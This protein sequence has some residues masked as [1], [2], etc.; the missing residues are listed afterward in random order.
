MALLYAA[1]RGSKVRKLAVLLLAGAALAGCG[2]PREGVSV[3]LI[4]ADS[5]RVDR[6]PLWNPGEAPPTPNLDR[7]AQRGAAYRNAWATSPWTAPAM[8]SVFTGLYPPSHGIVYRDDTTPETLPTLPRLLAAR[9]YRL[10][11][12]SFF[13]GISYFRNLGLGP[14]EEGIGH[15]RVAG[16]FRRWL[17]AVPAEQPFFAWVH[18][19]EPH[20]PYGA[21]G[22]RAT[23]AEV[24]GSSGLVAAQLDATVPWG[25][26]EFEDG[27]RGR[28]VELYDRDVRRMDEVLG[29]VLDA[30]ESEGRAGETLVI[31]VADHGEELLDD[32][33]IG[34]ASTAVRAK[35]LPEILRVPLILAGPGIPAGGLHDELVQQV[36]VLPTV[37]RLLGLGVP[38]EIDGRPL[39][40]IPLPGLVWPW[41]RGGHQLA[42][43]D[44]SPGGNL[45]PQD[46]RGERLQA[47]TDGADCLVAVHTTPDRPEEVR[48]RA[49]GD[50]GGSCDPAVAAALLGEI[51]PWR[52]RQ[53]RQRLAV[54]ARYPAGSAPPSEEVDRYAETLQVLEPSSGEALSWEAT[55]GQIALAWTGDGEKYWIEYR[56]SDLLK[57]SGSFQVEQQR[58][59]FGPIPQGF[60]NDLAGYSPFRIRLVDAE[61]RRRSAWV[62][63]RVLP[64]G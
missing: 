18:L 20:L 32:D 23:E 61:N 59:V 38:P 37:A 43:F 64:T 26:V 27:D 15:R 56:L 52:Q 22:Y 9:G 5:L 53:T 54:L 7:L 60:W 21:S 16:G 46:R 36:D 1:L 44:T 33:W 48:S 13:S 47:V 41:Q 39:P 2:H 31:F 19:L 28:L 55:G 10:G 25:T 29:R 35:M 11:N 4:S 34:H 6:L 42:F 40:G 63:Y 17:E 8:V 58:V 57:T 30:L 51:E 49:L 62:E 3:L 14:V 45:T 12:F 24:P 50:A